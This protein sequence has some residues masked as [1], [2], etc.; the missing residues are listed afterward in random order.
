MKRGLKGLTPQDLLSNSKIEKMRLS[1]F[2]TFGRTFL[3]GILTTLFNFSYGQESKYISVFSEIG[4]Y[5]PVIYNYTSSENVFIP[6]TGDNITINNEF[7]PK[8]TNYESLFAK[9][10]LSHKYGV[11]FEQ[12]W[13]HLSYSIGLSYSTSFNSFSYDHLYEENNYYGVYEVKE[14]FNTIVVEGLLQLKMYSLL[15][16]QLKFYLAGGA[17]VSNLIRYKQTMRQMQV[18]KMQNGM[19]N[20]S[21]FFRNTNALVRINYLLFLRPKAGVMVK[22]DLNSQLRLTLSPSIVFASQTNEKMKFSS[23]ST[24]SSGEYRSSFTLSTLFSVGYKL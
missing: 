5:K 16:D 15:E 22:W 19:K 1:L 3:L 23:F 24:Y 7:T 14:K 13:D 11:G 8:E 10:G 6:S 21:L 20:E 9:Y 4:F 17:E 18:G 12:E 2:S